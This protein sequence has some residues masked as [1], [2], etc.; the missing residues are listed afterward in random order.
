MAFH[1]SVA[2][3][4]APVAVNEPTAEGAGSTVWKVEEYA[5][6]IVAPDVSVT[7]ETVRR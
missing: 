1:V 3:R 6:P 2:A 4:T 5:V 7:P